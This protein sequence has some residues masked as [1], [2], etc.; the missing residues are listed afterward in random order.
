MNANNQVGSTLKRIGR[1]AYV[2]ELNGKKFIRKSSPPVDGIIKKLSRRLFSGSLPFRNEK[3]INEMLLDSQFKHFHFPKVIHGFNEKFIDFEYLHGRDA[4]IL[5]LEE[6]KIALLGLLEFNRLA[7]QYHVTGF[8]GIIFRLIESPSIKIL[9]LLYHSDIV[10]TK[11]LKSINIL[12]KY[13]LFFGNVNYVL[14]H[15]DLMFKNIIISN[16]NTINFIDFEDATKERVFVLADAVDILLDRKNINININ[17][18]SEYCKNLLSIAPKTQKK[19]NIKEQLRI[20]LL[21]LSL[22]S[23][24]SSSTSETEKIKMRL[25]FDILLDDEQYIMWWDTQC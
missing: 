12:L 10:A 25:L 15:N 11:K 23:M 2:M 7:G 4:D 17:I 16:D 1:S 13:H 6:K 22:A 19:I 18:L 20:C 9:K 14:I 5:N 3:R 24:L 21:R 8:E